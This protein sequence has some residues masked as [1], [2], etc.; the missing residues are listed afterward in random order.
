MGEGGVGGTIEG[1]AVSR[2]ARA[3]SHTPS[4]EGG[5]PALVAGTAPVAREVREREAGALGEV[6]GRVE[7]WA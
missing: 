2:P 3:R 5:A 7:G 6:S 4:Y 1:L